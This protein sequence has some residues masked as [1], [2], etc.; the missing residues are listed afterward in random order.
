MVNGTTAVT[1][2]KAEDGSDTFPPDDAVTV[3][4]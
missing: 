4:V 1:D 2:E 3:R